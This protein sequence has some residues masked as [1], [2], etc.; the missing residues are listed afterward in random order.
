MFLRSRWSRMT[1]VSLLA[2]AALALATLRPAAAADLKQLDTSLRLIPADAAFY[3]S[4]L[5]LREQV[6]LVAK[7]N[8]WKKLMDMPVISMGLAMY[9]IQAGNP[10]SVPGQIQ[11]AL[12]DPDTRKLIDL[13]VDLGSTEIFCFGDESMVDFANLA[14]RTMN[15]VRY[16]PIIMQVTGEAK[17][18]SDQEVQGRVFLSALAENPGLLKL[19]EMV[20]GFR[21]KNTA[22]ATEHL[23]KLEAILGEELAKIPELKGALKRQKVAGNEFLTL[24]LNGKMIPWDEIPVDMLKKYESEEGQVDK[25]VASVKKMTFVVAIGLRDDFL[26]VSMGSS[27]NVLKKL[28]QGARLIDSP[29]LR[30]LAAHADKR[31]TNITYLS[32]KSA[33]ALLGSSANIEE[34]LDVAK[35]VL[36]AA[37]LGEATDK[38]IL[39][40]LAGV[41]KDIKDV[42]PQPG[43]M[44]A[45]G[46]LVADGSEGYTYDWTKH[47][48]LDGTKPLTLLRHV[49][50]A[51]TAAA[52]NRGRP[53]VADYDRLVKW[54]KVG[55]G[56]FED[57]A[58][59]KMSE[60]EQA[61]AK[62]FLDNA[63]PHFQKLDEATRTLLLPALAD[64]QVGLVLDTKLTSKRFIEAL[65]PT[66]RDLPMFE[67]AILC[68]VSDEAKLVDAFRAYRQSIN[69]LIDAARKIE[70]SDIPP[71]IKIPEPQVSKTAAG[72]L[73]TWPLPEAWGVD[74]KIAPNFGV[75]K[76]VGVF[77]I[78]NE[79]SQRL[80]GESKL[81]AGGALSDTDKPLAGAV[82]F[83]VAGLLGAIKPWV[84][85]GFDTAIKESQGNMMVGAAAG[86]VDIVFEVLGVFRR[87]TSAAYFEGDALVTHSHMEIRDLKD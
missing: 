41:A 50:G 14:Q 28:G 51:P 74:K 19:P 15:A 70:G 4:S 10:E 27:T 22:S 71:Q 56:Y 38:R 68:G 57:L 77:A 8:A 85:F 61:Q 54:V 30:P 53:S 7:S 2:C 83:D 79:H 78:S 76:G 16:R 80:L 87:A 75:G 11:K 12:N 46:F 18:M 69:G 86:Q 42:M 58:L 49:G 23:Q 3:S 31:L 84:D 39:A 60:K 44:L 62:Q 81:A 73:Y 24:S 82:V 9:R 21:V 37:K 13:A 55:Y 59:P 6:D 36:P 66:H 47:A 65:P 35:Q 45:F 72:T 34:L 20:M 26:L 48:E 33:A 25:L 40:D 52:V 1:G 29:K 64:G 67:P 32:E 17:G 43:A 5:R 63:K